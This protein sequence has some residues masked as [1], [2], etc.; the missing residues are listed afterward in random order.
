MRDSAS[1]R[2]R[3]F[4]FLTFRDPKCVNTVMVKEHHLDGKIIDPKRAI[5]RDEQERTS[6][7]FVGGI[8]PNTTNESFRA[9]FLQ[10]GNILDHNLMFDKETGKPRGFGFITFET[11]DAGRKALNSDGAVW[12]DGKTVSF[13]LRYEGC[14]QRSL[15]TCVSMC[16]SC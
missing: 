13:P 9:T 2:S 5:P 3:G 14:L 15:L 8:P 11:E 10:F 1:G 7:I 6:K 4:G 16:A 12:L